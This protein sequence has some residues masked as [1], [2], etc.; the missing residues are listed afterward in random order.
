M[1]TNKLI[2]VEQLDL[3]VDGFAA[4]VKAAGFE[5]KENLKALAYVDEIA[6]T[7]VASSLTTIIE[8]KMDLADAQNLVAGEVG[9]AYRPGGSYTFANLPAPSA[10]NYGVIYNVTDD[11]TTTANFVEGAGKKYYAGSEVGVVLAEKADPAD[12]DVYVYNVFSGFVDISLFAKQ[13]SFTTFKEAL[14][15]IEIA[16]AAEIQAIIDGS[17]SLEDATPAPSPTP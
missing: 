11:F 16:T 7:H 4:E 15:N 1:A 6:S 13:S 14:D 3:A 10:A 9:M 8:A 17:L 5:K 2:T 12:P